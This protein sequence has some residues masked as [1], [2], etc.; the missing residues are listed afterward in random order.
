MNHYQRQLLLSASPAAVYQA[1]TT[2]QGLRSWW[3]QTCEVSNGKTRLDLEHVGLTPAIECFD[4]CRDGWNQYL[5]NLQ[6]LV[7]TG[8]G[9]PFAISEPAMQA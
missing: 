8:R 4:I 2:Q 3:T 1:L 7:E 9:H 6:S 5:G